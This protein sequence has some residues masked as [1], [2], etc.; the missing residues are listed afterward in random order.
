MRI[1]DLEA[2]ITVYQCGSFSKA[3][4][5]I[6]TSQPAISMAVQ[7]LERELGIL[8][9]DRTGSGARATRQGAAAIKA[10]MKIAQI[11]DGLHETAETIQALKIAVTPL[12]SGRDVVSM[13]Q[14]AMPDHSG[15]FDVE[16]LESTEIH[17]RPD[18]DVRISL[19]SLRKKSAFCV[20][21]PTEWIGVDNGVL[22]L[23]NQE[24][25]IWQRARSVLMNSG[26]AVRKVI[27]VND[28]GY[29]YHMA[30]AGA[31][32]TPCVMTRNIAFRGFVLDTLP[33]LAPVRLD[34]V[35]P[36]AIAGELRRL[37]T[38]EG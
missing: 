23:C 13:L 10:F 21:L 30:A 26:L 15:G 38:E 22:I 19:P 1:R 6:G 36:Y 9:F 31:G 4:E 35:A 27:T 14:M 25:E 3:A 34:I 28:C 7:R 20:E 2:V 8:L 11:V 5:T 37:M 32:F 29:A 33:P 17:Q 12:L 24:M 16:F 18:N